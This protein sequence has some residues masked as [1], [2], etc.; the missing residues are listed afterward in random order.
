VIARFESEDSARRNSDRPEQGAWWAETETLID[1]PQFADSSDVTVHLAAAPDDA[2][3]VQVMRG[4]IADADA[5]DRVQE[6]M[7]QMIADMNEARPD[8]LGSV[9]V[10]ESADRYTDVVYFTSEAEARQGEA[11]ELPAEVTRQ[12]DAMMSAVEVDDYLDL[13]DPWID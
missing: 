11:K 1:N 5:Y 4:R 10:R 13:R 8:V 7:A 9:T 6:G 3:F 2:G 12:F